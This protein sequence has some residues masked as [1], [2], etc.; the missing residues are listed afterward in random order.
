MIDSTDTNPHDQIIAIFKI[1]P[2]DPNPDY[3]LVDDIVAGSEG[4]PATKL[5]TNSILGTLESPLTDLSIVPAADVETS[6]TNT[7]TDLI[8]AGVMVPTAAIMYNYD[9]TLDDNGQNDIEV[10]FT[11]ADPSQNTSANTRYITPGVIEWTVEAT[12][13]NADHPWHMHGLSF[14]P[15]KME[16]NQGNNEYITL[17]TWDYVEY[18]DVMYI[19]AYHKFTYRFVI[20]DRLFID[21]NNILYP[22]GV[23]GRWLAHCHIVKHAHHGMMMEFIVVNANNSLTD[24]RFP[25]DIYLRD[26]ITDDGTVPSR[27]FGSSPDIILSQTLYNNPNTEFGEGA[28]NNSLGY[29][30]E[31]GQSNYIYVGVKNRSH[32]KRNA[33][34]VT[35]DVYWCEGSTLI[36]PNQWNYIGTTNPVVVPHGDTLVVANAITWKSVPVPG[37]YYLVGV[38]G[39]QNDPKT[40]TQSEVTNFIASGM[41]STQFVELIRNNN[42]IT[43]R[44]IISESS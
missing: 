11:V 34:N 24:R 23:F 9:I 4:L 1:E 39:N 25:T 44:H 18:M 15:I 7:I 30:A 28:D 5:R 43:F 33:T 35:T 21:T 13:A 40:L 41:T 37:N 19:P 36:I 22:G 29:Q 17:Y 32:D 6:F 27:E 3:E 8:E 10:I 12:T 14:Q 38:T 20:E 16:L 26:N 2:G 42:N 31:Y